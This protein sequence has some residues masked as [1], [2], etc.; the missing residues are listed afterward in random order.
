MKM[1]DRRFMYAKKSLFI[2]PLF[3]SAGYDFDEFILFNLMVGGCDL[4][5]IITIA[6]FGVYVEV[7]WY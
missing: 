4:H 6:L 5:E 7:A 2:G 3:L 1:I